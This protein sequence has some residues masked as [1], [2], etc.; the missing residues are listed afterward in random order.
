M[1]FK[2]PAMVFD[3]VRE[4]VVHNA[5]SVAPS[6]VK[7]TERAELFVAAAISVVMTTAYADEQ[8]ADMRTK[9]SI[10]YFGL[11]MAFNLPKP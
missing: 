7:S 4:L 2:P 9:E 8:T 5:H 11:E 10:F 3:G 1:L 6:A